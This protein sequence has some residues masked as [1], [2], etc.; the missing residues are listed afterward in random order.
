MSLWDKIKGLLSKNSDKVDM[1]IDKAGDL[2]DSKT[3]GK[4]KDTVDKVQ[5]AARGAVDKPAEAAAPVDKPA[6]AP[7]PA[8]KP[9]EAADPKP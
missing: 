8:D 7:A 2:V 4:Y 1:A 9:A 3:H 6:E 5:V